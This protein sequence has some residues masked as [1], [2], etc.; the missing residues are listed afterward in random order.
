VPPNFY[1]F[2]TSNIIQV[3]ESDFLIGISKT[4]NS[5]PIEPLSNILVDIYE[6]SVRGYGSYL[7]KAEVTFSAQKP[8]LKKYNS[9]QV[10]SH[11]PFE[12]FEEYRKAIYSEEGQRMIKSYYNLQAFI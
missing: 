3:F 4:E 7:H 11:F 8:I 9:L 6:Y 10:I 12:G 2:I 5:L 1:E